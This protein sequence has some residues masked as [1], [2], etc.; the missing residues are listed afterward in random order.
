[1]GAALGV[2]AATRGLREKKYRKPLLL[3]LGFFISIGAILL[4]VGLYAA[5]I[6]QPYHVWYP[7]TL[8]GAIVILLLVT[9]YFVLKKITD[10]AELREIETLD[11]H[12]NS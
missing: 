2:F 7:F 8:I 4:A 6:K 5:S 12:D 1:M 11:M 3:A 10:N 9:N